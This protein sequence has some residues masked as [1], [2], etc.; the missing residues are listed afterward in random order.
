MTYELQ[1][2]EYPI[3]LR[4][5]LRL[6][7]PFGAEF[8]PQGYVRVI[9]RMGQYAGVKGPGL[10]FV[11]RLTHGL[12]P[13]VLV[14]AQRTPYDFPNLLTRDVVPVRVRV[15]AVIG[16]DPR[17]APEFAYLLTRL[18]ERVYLQVAEVY[19]RWAL[20]AAVSQYNA[21]ELAQDAVT[22]QIEQA[23]TERVK[24]EMAFLG[25]QP[26]S[27]LRLQQVELPTTLIGR[28]ETIAQRRAS[29]LAGGEFHPAEFRRALV[30]E[31][32]ENLGRAGSGEA[33]VNFNELVEA[34]AAERMKG[35]APPA[36]PTID[37]PPQSTLGKDAPKPRPGKK[38]RL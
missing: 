28:Q 20:L 17:S 10:F 6:G 35:G 18:N 27:R 12:G 22:A 1:P 24:Q 32:I 34:Y 2:H 11:N 16:Y 3:L 29:V 21:T 19:I 7:R 25:I 31:V 15:N 26:L 23:V 5:L 8:V 13:L 9:N 37:N 33:F 38:S 36:P 30:T 4:L 14:A